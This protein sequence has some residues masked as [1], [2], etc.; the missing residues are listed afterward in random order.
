M[1]TFGG[2]SF[3]SPTRRNQALGIKNNPWQMEIISS[4][5]T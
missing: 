3:S 5:S 4:C 1:V 2:I